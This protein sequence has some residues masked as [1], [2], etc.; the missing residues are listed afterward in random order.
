MRFESP[1]VRYT[2]FV[3]RNEEERIPLGYKRSFL[4]QFS[5]AR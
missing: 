4:E 3:P 2:V 5:D 1:E